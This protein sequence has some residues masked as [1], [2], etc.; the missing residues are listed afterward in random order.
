MEKGSR[1]KLVGRESTKGGGVSWIGK[2]IEV[3]NRGKK[4]D[5]GFAKERKREI[6]SNFFFL[7]PPRRKDR[8]IRTLVPFPIW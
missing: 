7:H 3:E 6:D 4:R 2:A 8:E 1:E 5:A